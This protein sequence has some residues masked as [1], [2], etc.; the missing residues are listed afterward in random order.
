M[1][2]RY[3]VGYSLTKVEAPEKVKQALRLLL[4]CNVPYALRIRGKVTWRSKERTFLWEDRFPTGFLPKVLE[5]FPGEVV[6][7]R[8]P[9]NVTPKAPCLEGAELLDFQ[10]ETVSKIIEAKRCVISSAV[11]TGK[12]YV[13]A[14]VA[15]ALE[16]LPFLYLVHRGDILRQTYERFR[17]WLPSRSIGILG[18]GAKKEGRDMVCTFQSAHNLPTQDF[19]LLIVDECQH[20]VASKFMR[21][22]CSFDAPYCVGLTG[23]PKGRSDAADFLLGVLF[24]PTI[25]AISVDEARKLGLVCDARFFMVSVP[26]RCISYPVDDW[27]VAEDTCIVNNVTRNELICTIVEETR[28]EGVTLIIV[29]RIEH[30]KILTGLIPDAIYVDSHSS[31]EVRDKVRKAKEGVIVATG[32]V[33]EGLDNPHIRVIINAAAGKSPIVTTQRVGRGLRFSPGKTLLYFDFLDSSHPLLRKHSLRRKR[34]YQ[35]LG[36][37]EDVDLAG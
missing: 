25:Q 26:S 13:A 24:G 34:I 6:D 3:K 15:S 21:I 18:G 17:Q 16:E 9:I 32:I 31:W 8:A 23:T 35:T 19:K 29:R 4:T 12:T 7:N 30:G 10:K 11:S 14:A 28:K 36:R 2:T 1:I 33:E 27:Q 20:A 37:V 22:V 5:H